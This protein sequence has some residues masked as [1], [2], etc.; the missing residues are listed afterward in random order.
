ADVT[1]QLVHVE[2]T[3]TARDAAGAARDAAWRLRETT[4]P[5]AWE[6]TRRL[7]EAAR[8]RQLT[9]AQAA[10]PAESLAT[11]RRRL[12]VNDHG[13][14]AVEIDVANAG[15]Q[16]GRQD[17]RAVALQD[18]LQAGRLVV[19]QDHLALH[20]TERLGGAGLI[21]RVGAFLDLGLF[22]LLSEVLQD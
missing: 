5:A 11:G 4:W 7:W 1:R 10:Q 3:R 17:G 18:I 9:L 13:D 2:A 19:E 8:L 22:P 15:L 14:G 6:T 21:N 16:L 20:H 12:E